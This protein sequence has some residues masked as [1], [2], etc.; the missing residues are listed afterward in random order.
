M[1][2]R[3]MTG[4]DLPEGKVIQIYYEKGDTPP[5]G[6]I[7]VTEMLAQVNEGGSEDWVDFTLDDPLEEVVAWYIQEGFSWGIADKPVSCG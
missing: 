5:S 2:D 3:T 4:R 6:W 7:T 1:A